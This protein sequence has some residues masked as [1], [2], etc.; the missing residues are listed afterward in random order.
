[1]FLLER[2]SNMTV[3]QLTKYMALCGGGKSAPRKADRVD[4]LI[5]TLSSRQEIARLWREMD[6]LSRKAV[7]VAYHNDGHFNE[8]AFVAQYGSLPERPKHKWSWERNLIVVDLFIHGETLPPQIMVNLADLVPEPERFQLT[9][10]QEIPAEEVD[11]RQHP[12]P[13]TVALRQEA[14]RHDLLLFLSLAAQGALK[15]SK[16]N[17][18]LTPKGVETI[19]GQLQ[20]GEFAAEFIN[21]DGSNREIKK[22]DESICLFGLNTFAAQAGLL[23][24]EGNLTTEGQSYLAT[25]DPALLLEALETWTHNGLFDELTRIGA[26]RGLR[27][28]GIDL[29]DPAMRREKVVEA[30]S[31]CP[32]GEWISIPDF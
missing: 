14:G 10:S 16:T 23:D 22:I 8:D 21:K 3:D 25:E 9:G 20:E 18:R 27:A 17:G 11:S 24:K 30:L 5:R 26:L 13:Q 31:W 15:F 12:I 6:D 1:M 7:A 28:K 4:F 19:L 32:V 2:F 29:T